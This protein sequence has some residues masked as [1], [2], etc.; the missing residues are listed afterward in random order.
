MV[1]S[2][3]VSWL[4]GSIRTLVKRV[5]DLEAQLQKA[6]PMSTGSPI[7]IAE[8]LFPPGWN[9]DA[10]PFVPQLEVVLESLQPSSITVNDSEEKAL[11]DAE[12][13][14]KLE[15]E[16]KSAKNARK[17]GKKKKKEV[18]FSFD[19][20]KQD[21]SHLFNI[22]DEVFIPDNA[23]AHQRGVVIAFP[24]DMV[25]STCPGGRYRTYQ[26]KTQGGEECHRDWNELRP[27]VDGDCSSGCDPTGSREILS[28]AQVGEI[29]QK[30][31]DK[32]E[33]GEVQQALDMCSEVVLQ[34]HGIPESLVYKQYFIPVCG[35]M[36]KL[37]AKLGR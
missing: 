24:N 6:Q 15:T 29:M 3:L 12:V 25:D 11:E 4:A 37:A 20:I 5:D 7:S 34:L 13:E 2:Q 31:D 30:I 8:S 21:E 9:P 1:S 35:L 23:P 22:G 19:K 32:I 10:P 16:L 27:A 14:V 33:R 36:T 18:T 26:V 28:E 17:R